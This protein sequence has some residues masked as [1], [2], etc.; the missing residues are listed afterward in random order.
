[1]SFIPIDASQT[2]VGAPITKDLMDAIRLNAD[3][4]EARI[5][6]LEF[7]SVGVYILNGDMSFA[8]FDISRPVIFHHKAKFPYT[9]TDFRVQLFDKQGL[10]SGTLSFDLQKT[11]GVN[12]SDSTFNSGSI[13]TSPLSFN[14]AT[15]ADY[16]EKVAAIDGT[17]N[18]IING[19]VIRIKITSIP[20]GFT[21]MILISIGGQ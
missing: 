13:L 10:A 16:A 12:N 20:A 9:L 11:T 2:A 8:G 1:M 7:S 14:F 3:D 18:S 5:A 21:G 17:K 19:G 6:D 15:D 4:H